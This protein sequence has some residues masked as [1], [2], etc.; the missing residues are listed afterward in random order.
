MK[1][2]FVL[3]KALEVSPQFGA[4]DVLS[5]DHFQMDYL[6]QEAMKKETGKWANIKDHYVVDEKSISFQTINGRL[7]VAMIAYRK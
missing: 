2:F 3:Y 5:A 6:I 4:K 7:S 1:D